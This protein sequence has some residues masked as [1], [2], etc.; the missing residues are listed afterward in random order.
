MIKLILNTL[1]SKIINV[2][3]SMSRLCMPKRYHKCLH[4]RTCS[5]SQFTPLTKF[6]QILNL[7]EHSRRAC[8]RTNR[9]FTRSSILPTNVLASM[10]ASMLDRV[11]GSF[12]RLRKAL[13][14]VCN[15]YLLTNNFNYDP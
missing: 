9:P 5:L 10:F 15:S 12:L 6:K 13:L 1:N 8:S 7:V 4:D 11:N 14:I 2:L 3:M